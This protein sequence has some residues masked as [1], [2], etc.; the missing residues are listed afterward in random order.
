MAGEGDFERGQ[1]VA[2]LGGRFKSLF[3]G[4]V[5]DLGG[6]SRQQILEAAGK[7]NLDV[8]EML[9]V[10]ARGDF[11]GAGTRA[12]AEVEI[13]T[14]AIMGAGWILAVAKDA[15]DLF[16]NNSGDGRGWI[17]AVNLSG[18]IGIV[19]EFDIG[20]MEDGEGM[21][22]GIA[23]DDVADGFVILDGGVVVGLVSFDQV[24]LENDGGQIA[25]NDL[26]N[27][28]PGLGQEMRRLT[29][30]SAAAFEMLSE[31][32]L[33][34]DRFTNVQG[35]AGGVGEDIDPGRGGQAQW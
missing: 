25:F 17:G 22:G 29:V 24:G 4:S 15:S 5:F 19:L 14:G 6:E 18:G 7:K 34:V 8:G 11:A 26:K 27:E 10:G 2:L 20:A 3:S 16:Q 13:K 33:E 21:A 9:G 1:L 31:P 23:N 28:R 12:L 35:G 30:G 32:A